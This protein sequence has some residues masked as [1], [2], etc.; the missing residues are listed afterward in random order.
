[1]ARIVCFWKTSITSRLPQ[2]YSCIHMQCIE[3]IREQAGYCARQ[4]G[5]SMKKCVFVELRDILPGGAQTERALRDAFTITDLDRGSFVED[6]VVNFKL[7][8]DQSLLARF[9]S[10]A[11]KS[12]KGN[13]EVLLLTSEM[14]TMNFGM[15]D[16]VKTN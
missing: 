5:S 12:T 11:H 8:D 15:E 7:S 4:L 16:A 9:D 1:M 10:L 6:L 13:A 3:C 2:L 14:I